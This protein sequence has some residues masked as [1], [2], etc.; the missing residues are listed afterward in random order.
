MTQQSRTDSPS[1]LAAAMRILLFIAAAALA[2]VAVVLPV[3]RLTQGQAV[4]TVNLSDSA[5]AAAL[6]TVT[7]PDGYVEATGA[8]GLTVNLVVTSLDPGSDPAPPVPWWARLLTELGTS[9]WAL[10]LALIAY[11]LARVLGNI[12]AGDP[13]HQ[14]HARRF[15]LMAIAILVISVGAD[16]INYINA[17]VLTRA[18]GSPADLS[19]TAYYSLIPVALAAVTLVL[20][21]AFRAGRQI[22]EDTEGLV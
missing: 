17:T 11:L 5:S 14:S 19:V 18:I 8:D 6:R 15:T 2:L 13:F 16:T 10:G 9:I 20:A 21:S 12:A 4:A 22:Q 7:V 1:R 3:H